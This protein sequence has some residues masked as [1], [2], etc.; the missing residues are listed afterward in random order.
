MC[1]TTTISITNNSPYRKD[2][3]I[4]LQYISEPPCS[5]VIQLYV[6]SDGYC[7]HELSCISPYIYRGTLWGLSATGFLFS[8][9]IFL[10][11]LIS[12]L[13]G[14]VRRVSAVASVLQAGLLI[15]LGMLVFYSWRSSFAY[16][17]M[18]AP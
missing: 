12:A 13:A 4:Y 1:I 16:V 15:L 9:L 3:V 18:R 11:L 6:Y 14:W 8:C 5:F 10:V 2:Q 17:Q 7:W